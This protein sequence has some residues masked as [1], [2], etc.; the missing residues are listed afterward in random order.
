[1][2]TTPTTITLREPDVAAVRTWT[3]SRVGPAYV[4]GIPGW[5]W[6]SAL[7]TPITVRGGE[8]GRGVHRQRH[9]PLVDR[10]HRRSRHVPSVCCDV[11][12]LLRVDLGQGPRGERKV[13]GRDRGGLG[14]AR[15]EASARPR[16]LPVDLAQHAHNA[17]GGALIRRTH[18]PLGAR[19]A[20][21]VTNTERPRATGSSRDGRAHLQRAVRVS[22]PGLNEQV[23]HHERGRIGG[24]DR[25]RLLDRLKLV[26]GNE[27]TRNQAV[28]QVLDEVNEI[29][30]RPCPGGYT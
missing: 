15:R 24:A 6:Q 9:V 30:R 1:M 14:R 21:T 4:R 11:R 5:V 25:D 26:V 12:D 19:N 22:T 13:A 27:A 2:R 17:R 10:R 23:G 3:H 8:L 18:R 20:T 7:S 16:R 29:E 28:T